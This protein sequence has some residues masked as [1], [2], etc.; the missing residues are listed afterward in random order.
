MVFKKSKYS[1]KLVYANIYKLTKLGSYHI[2]SDFGGVLNNDTIELQE[3]NVL[4]IRV[5][6]NENDAIQC[7][8]KVFKIGD[9][10]IYTK[11]K[12]I[13]TF[14]FAY[15]RAYVEINSIKPYESKNKKKVMTKMK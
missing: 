15:N 7:F 6:S 4:L 1:S 9:K 8:L 14:P 10:F 12:K 13:D 11:G 5:N 2:V 3:K